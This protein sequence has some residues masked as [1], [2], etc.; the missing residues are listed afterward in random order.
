[1]TTNTTFEITVLN[2][3][4]AE[5]AWHG[6]DQE[7]AFLCGYN[8]DYGFIVGFDHNIGWN[9]RGLYDKI[10]SGHKSY[11]YIHILDSNKLRFI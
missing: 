9:K 2:N 5:V 7:P 1:M 8:P 3:L 10:L 4:D 6:S 11:L